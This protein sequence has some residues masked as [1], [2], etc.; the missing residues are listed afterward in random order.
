VGLSLSAYSKAQVYQKAYAD[1]Q[2]RRAA[3]GSNQFQ[4]PARKEK[5]KEAT[6]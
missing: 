1:Y 3:L 5:P 6:S 2:R 4:I